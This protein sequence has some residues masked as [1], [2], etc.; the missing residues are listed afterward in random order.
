MRAAGSST[1]H[2]RG[3]EQ[4]V[5]QLPDLEPKEADHTCAERTLYAFSRSCS[6]RRYAHQTNNPMPQCRCHVDHVG[7]NQVSRRKRAFATIA[8]VAIRT[9]CDSSRGQDAALAKVSPCCRMTACLPR[10]MTMSTNSACNERTA[11]LMAATTCSRQAHLAASARK[12]HHMQPS[13]LPSKVRK[14]DHKKPRS[15]SQG[16]GEPTEAVSCTFRR[17]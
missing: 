12:H 16:Q 17:N 1:L 11:V 3:Q 8:L 4:Y 2:G 6:T 5:S 10:A 14:R 13:I 15:H 7:C 9:H